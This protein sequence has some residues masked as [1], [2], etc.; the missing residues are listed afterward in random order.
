MKLPVKKECLKSFLMDFLASCSLLERRSTLKLCPRK[1]QL[2]SGW[3]FQLRRPELRVSQT[4]CRTVACRH[5]ETALRGM[6]FTL[7]YTCKCTI[8]AQ[9]LRSMRDLQSALPKPGPSTSARASPVGRASAEALQSH[10]RSGSLETNYASSM[11]I[12]MILAQDGCLLSIAHWRY[13]QSGRKKPLS[14]AS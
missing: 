14:S 13:R 11:L 10:L 8:L 2:A 6:R 9:F 4:R 5:L 3:P 1:A 12:V 7:V